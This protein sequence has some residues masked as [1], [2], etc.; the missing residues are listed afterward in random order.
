MI[1]EPKRKIRRRTAIIVILSFSLAVAWIVARP[2]IRRQGSRDGVKVADPGASQ[3]AE[4]RTGKAR[5]DMDSLAGV[6]A[7]V[8]P[9]PPGAEEVRKRMDEL[10]EASSVKDKDNE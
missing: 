5:A 8:D 6:A 1:Y 7:R 10:R 2:L 4:R 3:E 9:D